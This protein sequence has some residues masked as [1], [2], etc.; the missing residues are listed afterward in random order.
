MKIVDKRVNNKRANFGSFVVL[1][2][3]SYL[4]VTNYS[5]FEKAYPVK[6]FS[7]DSGLFVEGVGSLDELYIGRCIG[8]HLIKDIITSSEATLVIGEEGV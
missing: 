3:E 4:F 7:I 2:D 5:S 8:D 6:L 1:D